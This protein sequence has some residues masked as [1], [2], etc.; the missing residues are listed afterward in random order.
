MASCV[1]RLM[2]RRRERQAPLF[3]DGLMDCPDALLDVALSQAARLMRTCCLVIVVEE[4]VTAS[5]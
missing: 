2:A 1:S 4:P 5:P 3:L